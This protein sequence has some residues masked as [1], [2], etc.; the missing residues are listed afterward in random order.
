MTKIESNEKVVNK[1]KAPGT[2]I[3]VRIDEPPEEIE[4]VAHSADCKHCNGI[5]KMIRDPE[6][7]KLQPDK[8]W[9]LMCGQRYF[10]KIENSIEEWE[11]K[12]WRQKG[13]TFAMGGD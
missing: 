6:T 9:C 11:L 7:F 8:C 10:V 13:V 5:V 4:M 3:D 2:D 12:Q 1:M